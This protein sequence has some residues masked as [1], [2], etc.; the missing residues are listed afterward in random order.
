M[1]THG[2]IA[3]MPTLQR[4]DVTIHYEVHGAGRPVVLIHGFCVT[5]A[6]NFTLAGWVERLNDFQIIGWGAGATWFSARPV[7]C[8]SKASTP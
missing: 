4:D 3:A 2:M 7:M 5:F 1:F 6:A 8:S